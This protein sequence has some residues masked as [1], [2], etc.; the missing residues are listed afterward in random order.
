MPAQAPFPHIQKGTAL[1]VAS[2]VGDS[3]ESPVTCSGPSTK[4]GC[5]SLCQHKSNCCVPRACLPRRDQRTHTPSLFQRDLSRSRFPQERAVRATIVD[6]VKVRLHDFRRVQH[7]RAVCCH[8]MTDHSLHTMQLFLV[9]FG[10]T[11]YSRAEK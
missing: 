8:A 5:S 7:A 4:H 11:L 6:S 2:R 1:L 10:W 9:L 3:L